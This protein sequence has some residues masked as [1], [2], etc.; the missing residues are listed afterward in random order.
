MRERDTRATIPLTLASRISQEVN[1]CF[2]SGA[3]WE[4][5]SP[6][7]SRLLHFWFD[8]E[9]REQRECNF[10]KGQEQAIKNMIYLYEVARVESVAQMYQRF[11]PEAMG[12]ILNE[13]AE[14][15]F[16]KFCIK[17]ATGTGK[18]WVMNALV[19]WQ[20]CN[21]VYANGYKGI[22]YFANFVL[23]APG[24]IV[25][26]RLLDSYQGRVGDNGS[27]DVDSSDIMQN[28]ALFV[29]EEWREKVREFLSGSVFD[30]EGK[31]LESRESGF[32]LLSN[33]HFLD[34]REEVAQRVQSEYPLENVASIVQGIL[35]LYPSTANDLEK[36]DR[37]IKA[38]EERE[39]L[40]TLE[41]LC[42]INDEAHHIYDDDKD[43]KWEGI[44]KYIS[45]AIV[46]NGGR[47]M[48]CDFSATPYIDKK[49]K[50]QNVKIH[51]L[52]IIV[53]FDLK[54][55]IDSALVKNISLTQR[56]I[57][58]SIESLDFRAR[59]DSEGKILGLS[60]G[61]EV[62][63]DAGLKQLEL[64]EKEFIK[65]DSSKYP[66]MLIMCEQQEVVE[67]V[68]RYL[69][70]RGLGGESVLSIHSGKKNEIG[71]QEY[72]RIKSRLFAMD[73]HKE[74]KV[75]ISVL[76]LREG[77]DVG[78]ICVIVPLRASESAILIE[79]TIGRGL[80]LMWRDNAGAL[81]RLENLKALQ[82]GQK[83]A[84]Y[85]DHLVIVEHPSF[86]RFYDEMIKNHLVFVDTDEQGGGSVTG[87][88]LY[89][90]LKPDY[91]AYDMAWH[92]VVSS[93]TQTRLNERLE[94]L[95]QKPLA[96][97]SAF[98]LD[99]LKQ[100]AGTK[101]RFILENFTT[102]TQFGGFEIS[103]EL[104]NAGAYS[105][106][107]RVLCESI[108][109]KLERSGGN[110]SGG[111]GLSVRLQGVEHLLIKRI[112]RYIRY[113]LFKE[114]FNPL[115]SSWRVLCLKDVG[116]HIIKV[117]LE[118]LQ[119]LESTQ[120]SI[121]MALESRYFSE[122]EGFRHREQFCLDGIKS[123]YTHT[124]FPSNKGGLER[125]FIE[126]IQKQGD[127]VRFVKILESKH[128]FA[129]IPYIRA[130]GVLGRYFVDFMAEGEREVYIIETKSQKDLR[131]EDVVRKKRAAISY[132]EQVNA[133][134]AIRGQK[135]WRYVLVGEGSLHSIIARGGGIDDL[136]SLC[137][138]E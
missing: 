123:I 88:M 113:E 77:F 66:K 125:V 1:E 23:L 46:K 124:P 3:I 40:S 85:I 32:L 68:E 26:E 76:M 101:E 72:L 135:L 111:K 41:N 5:V 10:H 95:L 53:D 33:W 55:A 13:L 114:S 8:E 91:E 108:A 110:V 116:E 97:F 81:M 87:D 31:K 42:I 112:D 36:L 93:H 86:Q 84:N 102:Q 78:N 28:A 6:V 30:K 67:F 133:A 51:F 103:A 4:S 61:Q 69:E 12:G 79:Q 27:R 15:S 120:E 24:L 59:R 70:T 43:L 58:S 134:L 75:V 128:S 129:Y 22:Q 115:D 74:P 126:W 25:Y 38:G 137:G 29:P 9:Y 18:T 122:V 96:H 127:I 17:M 117:F 107:L 54:T 73:K 50:K 65:L 105:E 21:A 48:Q 121:E 63:I 11:Y 90:G 20:Y 92:R 34:E 37:A 99:G 104:F 60:Q 83:P 118:L 49:L 130:D 132:V 56:N 45:Q 19:L 64:L 14:S 138:G 7:T 35:P 136:V 94:A 52:H 39:Y 89:V 109:G 47:F 62:M 119:E 44:I 100:I 2:E 16:V 106:F 131:A 82:N 71:E 98:S 80:R 57:L